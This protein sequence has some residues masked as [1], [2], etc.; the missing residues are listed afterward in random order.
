MY[1][2]LYFLYHLATHPLRELHSKACQQGT[3]KYSYVVMW[4]LWFV[5]ICLSLLW[6]D[7]CDAMLLFKCSCEILYSLIYYT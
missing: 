7:F 2:G 5:Q 6:P 1:P 4:L 3:G